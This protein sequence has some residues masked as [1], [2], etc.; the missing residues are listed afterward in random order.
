[1]LQSH[2][3][4]CLL[5]FDLFFTFL[6]VQSNPSIHWLATPLSTWSAFWIKNT[7]WADKRVDH[8]IQWH[9]QPNGTVSGFKAEFPQCV[10][11]ARVLPYI[12]TYTETHTHTYIYI[13][14][15][16]KYIY[17]YIPIGWGCRIH[18]L[19]LCKGVRLPHKW[20]SWIAID[21]YISGA[22]MPG[23]LW[24]GVVAPDR[25]LSMGQ[26]EVFDI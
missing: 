23:P 21:I 5:A 7:T 20:V 8:A 18:Q 14:T 15:Y 1:M 17:I 25:V 19:L 4:F 22:T 13:Y 24:P 16:T 10:E 9:N 12:Y 26:I 3:L 6:I 2:V 11:K